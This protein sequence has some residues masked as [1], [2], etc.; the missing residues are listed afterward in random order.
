MF[1]VATAF[2]SVGVRSGASRLRERSCVFFG[3][4]VVVMTS[5]SASDELSRQ[6]WVG[7]SLGPRPMLTSGFQKCEEVGI[8]LI[9]KRR[10]RSSVDSLLSGLFRID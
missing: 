2:K 9:R 10:A 3:V 7:L 5:S 8:D 1:F 6:S 4:S